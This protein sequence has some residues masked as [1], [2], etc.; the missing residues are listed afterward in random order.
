MSNRLPVFS[1]RHKICI[2]CEGNE[3]SDVV[4]YF[5]HFIMDVSYLE[6]IKGN[7]VYH[8]MQL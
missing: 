8:I 3:E 2:I 6:A 7:S 1:N 4:K 5:T